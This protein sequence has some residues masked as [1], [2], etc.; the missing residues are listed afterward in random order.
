MLQNY[1]RKKRKSREKIK[2]YQQNTF[3]NSMNSI[4]S[5]FYFPVIVSD[6]HFVTLAC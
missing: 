5:Q 4:H 3:E 6:F 2:S 1:R